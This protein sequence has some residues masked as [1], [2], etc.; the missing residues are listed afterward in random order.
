MLCQFL[1]YHKVNQL[2]IYMYPLFLGFP[3]HLAHHRALSRVPCAIQ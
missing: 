1:L 2:Y 3:S